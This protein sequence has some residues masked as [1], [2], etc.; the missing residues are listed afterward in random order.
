MPQLHLP[1]ISHNLLS[2][3]LTISKHKERCKGMQIEGDKYRG[4]GLAGAS[5]LMLFDVSVHCPSYLPTIV[6]AIRHSSALYLIKHFDAL[7]A[8]RG[9]L[10][11]ETACSG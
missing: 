7:G 4:M 5:T 2:E 1:Q 10:A 3:I 6:L 8:R 9:G 11:A